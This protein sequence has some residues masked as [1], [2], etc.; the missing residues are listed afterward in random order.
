MP[1]PSAARLGCHRD[2]D[3]DPA[4]AV[5]VQPDLADGHVARRADQEAPGRRAEPVGEPTTVVLGGDRVGPKPA[6]RVTGSL[7]QARRRVRQRRSPAAA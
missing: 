4:I 7:A 5:A 3:L 6:A 1:D 2:A